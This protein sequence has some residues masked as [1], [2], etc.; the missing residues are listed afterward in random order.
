MPIELDAQQLRVL[1]C[2]LEKAVLTPDQYP[3]TLNALTAACNQKSSRDPVMQMEPGAVQRTLRQLEDRHLV[4]SNENFRSRV[5]KFQQRFCNT[6]YANYQFEPDEYAVVTLLMLRGEQTP[7]ELRSRSG[8]LHEF[9]D[10]AE[11]QR[12]LDRLLEREDG[13]LVA[14]R[15]R[16]PGRRDHCWAHCFGGAVDSVAAEVADPAPSRRASAAAGGS[17]LDELE[18]RVA[19]LEARLAELTGEPTEEAPP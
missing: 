9:A 15:P 14:R 12:T 7:G 10:N 5:E 4:A 11:V 3:L 16:Q 8:R 17:R 1:G 13:P 18:A 2:L 6:P 19:R